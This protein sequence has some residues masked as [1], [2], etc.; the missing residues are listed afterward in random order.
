MPNMASNKKLAV[1]IERQPP[2]TYFELKSK[3]KNNENE[4]KKIDL[5][6]KQ[7]IFGVSL[8]IRARFLA[9]SVIFLLPMGI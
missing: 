9:H 3:I 7:I 4:L 2:T 6:E 5:I 8:T 1:T